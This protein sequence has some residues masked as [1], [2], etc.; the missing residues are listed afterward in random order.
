MACAPDD[1]DNKA[2]DW[3]DKESEIDKSGPS[4]CVLPAIVTIIYIC[5]AKRQNE[6]R[7][8]NL[9]QQAATQNMHNLLLVYKITT[10]EGTL[11]GKINRRNFL[12]C[13]YSIQRA[14]LTSFNIHNH[15]IQFKFRQ[16]YKLC[17][18]QHLIINAFWKNACHRSFML[19]VKFMHI[20]NTSMLT[21][22]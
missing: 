3:E 10:Q 13:M 5:S 11:F 9:Q 20:I 6:K 8:H 1:F 14:I 22:Y 16:K 7:W 18:K 12:L 21:L 4:L 19:E 15:N 2:L 17:S